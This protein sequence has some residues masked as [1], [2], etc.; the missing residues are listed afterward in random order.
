M[1]EYVFHYEAIDD[2]G[3]IIHFSENEIHYIGDRVVVKE[4]EY[5]ILDYAYEKVN[6][7]M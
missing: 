5:T 7:D 3:N 4:Q 1:E 6:Q 2:K